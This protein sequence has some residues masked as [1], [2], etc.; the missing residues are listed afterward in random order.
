M[1]TTAGDLG[2][3]IELLWDI[4][5][6]GAKRTFEK[7]KSTAVAYIKALVKCT[8][9][10]IA[11]FFVSIILKA[12]TGWVYF[13]YIGVFPSILLTIALI[14]LA[15]PLGILFGMIREETVNPA[16]A[17]DGYF[18]FA[19]AVFFI[20]L[21]AF[22]YT[23]EMPI[24][25]ETALKMTVLGTGLAVGIYRFGSIFPPKLYNV[26]IMGAMAYTTLT[27]FDPNPV[28]FI[29]NGFNPTV[30][31]YQGQIYQP[32]E[33][34]LVR[35]KDEKFSEMVTLVGVYKPEFVGWAEFRPKGSNRIVTINMGETPNLDF[36]TFQVRSPFGLVTFV[37]TG[38]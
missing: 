1:A 32:N 7:I 23:I 29:R 27:L 33:E 35:N 26:M 19:T 18:K 17:G 16:T 8:A 13:A 31:R 4:W 38:E 11:V 22:I 10:C 9:L 25:F 6:Y 5:L 24:N 15:S 2:K 21:L 12:L 14:L 20:E 36:N 28:K 37:P 34:I 3:T 30:S